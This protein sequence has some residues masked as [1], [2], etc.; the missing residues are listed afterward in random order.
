MVLGI[1]ILNEIAQ[2]LYQRS[3]SVLQAEAAAVKVTHQRGS[4]AA[5]QG[6]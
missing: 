5:T 4:V 6:C 1:K 2:R 3:W